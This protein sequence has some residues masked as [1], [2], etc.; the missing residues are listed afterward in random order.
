MELKAQR[1]S[2]DEWNKHT[3]TQKRPAKMVPRAS[4]GHGERRI[5]ST[6]HTCSQPLGIH[7]NFCS[8]FREREEGRK[9][10]SIQVLKA[11]N[12]FRAPWQAQ[13]QTMKEMWRMILVHVPMI[14]LQPN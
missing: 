13:H 4:S 8:T 12:Y 10:L 2:G 11:S 14:C 5:T 9:V 6:Y 7:H 1:K 3:C